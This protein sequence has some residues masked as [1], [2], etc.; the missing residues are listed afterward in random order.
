MFWQMYVSF[1]IQ[2]L[3]LNKRLSGVNTNLIC[4][5]NRS[6]Y[7]TPEQCNYASF[8]SNDGSHS[9]YGKVGH[10]PVSVVRSLLSR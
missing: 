6:Y 8:M 4:D 9:C 2:L 1:V 10:Q 7:T 5:I 3:P